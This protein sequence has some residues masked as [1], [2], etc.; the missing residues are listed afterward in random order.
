MTAHYCVTDGFA[1]YSVADTREAAIAEYRLH[2]GNSGAED[3]GDSY[4]GDGSTVALPISD[5][6]Y[7][8]V[9]DEGG[10]IDFVVAGRGCCA[11]VIEWAVA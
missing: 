3:I 2:A 11:E 8:R 9:L 5:S 6:M 1:I 4:R 7:Q 10:N